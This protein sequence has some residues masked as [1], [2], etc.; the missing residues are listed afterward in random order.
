MARSKLVPS[1][2]LQLTVDAATDRIIEDICSLGIHG[3]N[4]S[5]VACSIIR[6]WLW[7]NQDKLRDNGVA[8]N[9]APKKESGRG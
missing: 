4:K 1:C 9:V 6:M 7:E 3:T 8:L 5:E 2:K